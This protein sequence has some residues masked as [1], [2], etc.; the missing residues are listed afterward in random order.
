MAALQTPKGRNEALNQLNTEMAHKYGITT[1]VGSL[2]NPVAPHVGTDETGKQID[3]PTHVAIPFVD[4]KTGT[5]GKLPVP[6][7]LFNQM[8]RDFQDRYS[9]LNQNNSPSPAGAAPT[10]T[11]APAATPVAPQD[12]WAFLGIPDASPTAS[13]EATVAPVET[14]TPAPTHLGTYN[15]ATGEFE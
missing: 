11:P 10:S 7:P 15:P 6:M 14:P 12:P 9:E 5:I 13:P 8:K 4:Q 3:K 2:F 1:G